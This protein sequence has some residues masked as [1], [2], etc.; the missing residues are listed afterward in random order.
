M[1]IKDLTFT[2]VQH[3]QFYFEIFTEKYNLETKSIKNIPELGFTGLKIVE[4]KIPLSK[5]EHIQYC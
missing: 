2:I 5:Y 4:N 1:N 3:A